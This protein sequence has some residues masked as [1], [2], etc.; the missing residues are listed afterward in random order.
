MY[1]TPKLSSPLSVFSQQLSAGPTM[2]SFNRVG[3]AR[4]YCP[5]LCTINI[6]KQTYQKT[7]KQEGNW[8]PNTSSR[9]LVHKELVP[10]STY[11]SR[12][13]QPKPKSQPE[14]AVIRQLGMEGKA[15]DHTTEK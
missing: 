14:A 4:T 6:H 13:Q 1:P 12:M 15:Y 8:P 7:L 10:G 3:L 11:A 5:V 2:A 9:T